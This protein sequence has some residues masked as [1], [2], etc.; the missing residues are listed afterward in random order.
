[1]RILSTP[2]SRAE[3]QPSSCINLGVWRL[4]VAL[5]GQPVCSTATTWRSRRARAGYSAAPPV[6]LEGP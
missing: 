5:D 4:D 1:M 3:P 2:W 6:S